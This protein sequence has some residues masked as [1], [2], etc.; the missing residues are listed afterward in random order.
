[1]ASVFHICGQKLRD[2]FSRRKLP[3]MLYLV[4]HQDDE[5]LTLGVDACRIISAGTH[6]VHAALLCDGSKSQIRQAL[7][8]GKT[9]PHHPGTHQYSLEIPEFVAARDREFRASC[10]AIGYRPENIHIL[11]NRAIDCGLGVEFA[12]TAITEL[13]SRYPKQTTVCTISPFG[14]DAQHRDHATLGQAAL[15][16]YRKGII[17][18][19]RFFVEPYCVDSCRNAYPNLSLN[20]I[21]ANEEEKQRLEQSVGAYSLW[22]PDQGRYAIGFHS[23]TKAFREFIES[24]AAYCHLPGDLNG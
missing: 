17:R 3:V 4:P 24:P 6:E 8:N 12:E 13:L 7:R 9:C 23:V 15:N 10:E 19:L 22:A 20:V 2:L 16:L 5:L 18:E 1:M 14:G 21:P 11:P